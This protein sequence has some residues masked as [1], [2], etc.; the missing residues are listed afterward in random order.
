MS[1][2]HTLLLL[3]PS[4]PPCPPANPFAHIALLAR[5]AFDPPR[6]DEDALRGLVDAEETLRKGSKSFEVAKLA[7]GREMRIGLV[8][9]YAWCRVTVRRLGSQEVAY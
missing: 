4:L 2:L 7:F 9:V 8:A 6:I 1:H 5:V 3:S